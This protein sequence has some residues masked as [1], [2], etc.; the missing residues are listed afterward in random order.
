MLMAGAFVVGRQTARQ[1]APEATSEAAP[2]GEPTQAAGQL[3]QA[4]IAAPTEAEAGQP[5]EFD[6]SGSEAG[7]APIVRYEWEFG[8]GATGEGVQAS[9][10]YAA[11]GSYM[12]ILTVTD[13]QEQSNSSAPHEV[14][15]SEG[16]AAPAAAPT[17]NSFV[18]SP[19]Q[20][21]AGECVDLTWDVNPEAV[22]VVILRDGAPLVEG[23]SSAGQLPDCPEVAGVSVYRLEAYSADGQL[24]FKEQPVSIA[25]GAPTP[26]SALA[27]TGWRVRTLQMS[28]PP[29][30]GTT[31]TLLFGADGTIS[32]NDGCS[33]YT[34]QYTASGNTLSFASLSSPGGSCSAEINTQAQTYLSLL[35]TVA[36]FQ[37]SGTLLSLADGTGNEVLRLESGGQ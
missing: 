22:R 9:H 20:I 12:V 5:V 24:A 30:D 4:M 23:A 35:G 3:P 26:P 28:Q 14:V 19:D 18:V 10:T 32:G 36:A 25:A 31:I 1:A 6:G 29:L 2:S 33:D 15:V 7:S 11:A 34:G 13:E 17:I 21:A 37:T 27:G 16:A 8:D